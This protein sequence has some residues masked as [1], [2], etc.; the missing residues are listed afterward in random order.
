[1]MGTRDTWLAPSQRPA[2]LLLDMDPTYHGGFLP[3]SLRFFAMISLQGQIK[4]TIS[5]SLL[6][7]F[8]DETVLQKE[9][10]LLTLVLELFAFSVTKQTSASAKHRW[11]PQGLVQKEILHRSVYFVDEVIFSWKNILREFWINSS[12]IMLLLMFSIWGSHDA[13]QT[14]IKVPSTMW[15]ELPFEAE[16]CFSVLT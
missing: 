1:M 14:G 12:N 6:G 15:S 3:H 10:L 9:L 13:L 16:L 8:K 7:Y 11:K 5:S 4:N 2:L